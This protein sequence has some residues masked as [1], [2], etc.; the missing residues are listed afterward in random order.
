[1]AL[2]KACESPDNG[3]AT[4]EHAGG[5]LLAASV[6]LSVWSLP[7]G[8]KRALGAWALCAGGC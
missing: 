1:M 3:L 5:P 2:W 7:W 8:R 4:L 6:A